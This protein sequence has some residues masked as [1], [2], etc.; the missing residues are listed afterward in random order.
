MVDKCTDG[1][2]IEKI[3]ELVKV[4]QSGLGD[5]DRHLLTIFAIAKASKSKFY[6]ELGVRGGSTTLPILMAAHQNG[7]TLHSVD[8]HQTSFDCPSA[9]KPNWSFH[10]QNS[11][12]FLQQ[13]DKNIRV[14]FIYV[15]DWHS[16]DHVANEL[17]LI[18]QM[19][20]PSSVVLLHDLMWGNHEPFY[21]C[22]LTLTKGQWANGGPYR[23]VAELDPQLWEFSTL[24]WCNGLTLLRKKYSSKYHRT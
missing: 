18:D 8:L 2:F 22:D 12:E 1:E 3:T 11:I 16:Y 10:R 9:Y 24:P 17:A 23:A 14:D 6:F 5:S 15:D 4:S 20:G 21:H 19:I 7:G 13:W